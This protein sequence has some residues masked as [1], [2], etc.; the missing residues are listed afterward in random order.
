MPPTLI[1]YSDGKRMRRRK[2]NRKTRKRRP[3]ARK[4][5]VHLG[6]SIIPYSQQV[7][8][9]YVSNGHSITSTGGVYATH[10]FNFMGLYDPDISGVGHQPLG[11]D[12]MMT[13]YDHYQVLGVKATFTIHYASADCVVGLATSDD[14]TLPT[15]YQ[16]IDDFMENPGNQYKFI[17]QDTVTQGPC[18]LSKRISPSK[19]FGLKKSQ[20]QGEDKYQG[21][22]SAN[23]S[24]TGGLHLLCWADN[25]ADCTIR[26]TVRFNFISRFTEPKPLDGS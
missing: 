16:S 20:F 12:Q 22:A 6:K 21:T 3:L 4:A 24:E 9:T 25:G 11:F 18:Y 10:A 7:G 14:T 26:W 13:L 5:V 2:P 1:R 23:P 8:L 17:T 19:F 15:V